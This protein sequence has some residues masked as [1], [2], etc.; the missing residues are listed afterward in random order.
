MTRKHIFTLCLSILLLVAVL[1]TALLAAGEAL[2]FTGTAEG[3]GCGAGSLSLTLPEYVFAGDTIS[4]VIS[5]TG[6]L[7]GEVTFTSAGS[8]SPLPDYSMIFLATGAG[9][10]TVTAGGTVKGCAKSEA[11]SVAASTTILETVIQ[12]ETTVT[13]LKVGESLKPVFSYSRTPES[14]SIP[15]VDTLWASALQK[16][17]TYEPVLTVTGTSVSVSGSSLAALEPGVSVIT[18]TVP[19]TDISTSFSVNVVETSDAVPVTTL[20]VQ[21]SASMKVGDTLT[22]TPVYA[23]ANAT[24]AAG[25]WTLS[26]QNI[27]S[28]SGNTFTALSAGKVTATYILADS[29]K[30]ASCVITVVAG[31]PIAVSGVSLPNEKHIKV[32]DTLTLTPSFVP[33]NASNQNGTWLLSA[34]G[35]VSRYGNDFT[36]LK[37]GTVNVIFQT[38]DGSKVATCKIVVSGT[39]QITPSVTGITAVR[40]DKSDIGWIGEEL[41]LKVDSTYDVSFSVTPADADRSALSWASTAPE[42]ATV[43]NGSLTAMGPGTTKITVSFNGKE[44]ASFDV[45]VE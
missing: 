2:G 37:A 4:A 25:T 8:L 45:T 15:N 16:L 21:S 29:T 5:N 35:I 30:S 12:L 9:S 42:V 41:S 32:G 40:I 34:E 13:T 44:L 18:A 43:Y 36:G 33:S 11:L 31:G 6:E 17:V 1:P 38:E 19:G 28:V 14:D 3:S 10:G 39:T 27:V 22:I 23:P 20:A 24:N 26:K 7:E